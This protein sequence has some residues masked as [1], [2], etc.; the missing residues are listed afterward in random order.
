MRGR[1]AAA[2][3]AVLGLVLQVGDARAVNQEAIDRA[4]RRLDR[5]RQRGQKVVPTTRRYAEYVLVFTT[6]PAS[7]ARVEQVRFGENEAWIRHSPA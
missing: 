6:L 2:V 3:L 4:Q 7:E 5:K 1:R